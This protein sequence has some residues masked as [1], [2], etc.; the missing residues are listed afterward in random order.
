MWVKGFRDAS[1]SCSHQNWKRFIGVIN[2]HRTRVKDENIKDFFF[3]IL[4]GIEPH[5]N[6]RLSNCRIWGLTWPLVL[7]EL[8]LISGTLSLELRHI[9]PEKL[10]GEIVMPEHLLQCSPYNIAIIYW[11]D[12]VP[13]TQKISTHNDSLHGNTFSEMSSLK[14]CLW[15]VAQYL[16]YVAPK[17][18]YLYS[19]LEFWFWIDEME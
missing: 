2:A 12:R 19:L 11:S 18:F 15:F 13:A 9:L 7:F 8:Y 3:D 17:S 6:I 10:F 4:K 14:W 5:Q 1:Y 16:I